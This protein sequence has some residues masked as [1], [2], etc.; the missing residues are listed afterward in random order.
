[1]SESMVRE[2]ENRSFEVGRVLFA[3]CIYMLHTANK[4]AVEILLNEMLATP[5]VA[6]SLS[7]ARELVIQACYD[8]LIELENE[9]TE[10]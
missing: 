4:K 2:L 9:S 7:K 10:K 6:C 3:G 8:R 1:M 5:D